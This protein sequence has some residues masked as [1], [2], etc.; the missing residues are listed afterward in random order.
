MLGLFPLFQPKGVPAISY[1]CALR[2]SG[3]ADDPFGNCWPSD[4][5]LHY[6]AD[7]YYTAIGNDVSLI[8]S[9][10]ARNCR[11]KIHWADGCFVLSNSG[12]DGHFIRYDLLWKSFFSNE[13]SGQGQTSR[14][15]PYR[16]ASS[17]AIA[18]V[19]SFASG[20]SACPVLSPGGNSFVK[21]QAF[22]WIAVAFVFG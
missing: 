3:L 14:H 13:K 1:V 18:A 21:W 11:L 20:Q 16:H 9:Y 10:A 4:N 22:H 2:T 8:V 17:F 6:G 5:S 7:A 12:S 15:R 19:V